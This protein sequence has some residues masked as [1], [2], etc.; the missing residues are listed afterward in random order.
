MTME[1]HYTECGLDN[2]IILVDSV[3]A[4]DGETVVVIPALL[5]L[6]QCIAE[7]VINSDGILNGKEIRFLRTEM[8]MTQAELAEIMHRDSQTIARWEKNES[9]IDAGHDLMLRQV[10]AEKLDIS[11]GE[12]KTI[13]ELSRERRATITPQPIKMKLHKDGRKPKYTCVA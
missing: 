4:D 8:G 2:V 9:A 3:E 5:Q 11:F 12:D 7:M 13:I 6:H 10:A 1:Y